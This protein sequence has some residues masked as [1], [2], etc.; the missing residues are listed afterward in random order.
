MVL[1][2]TLHPDQKDETITCP[3]PCGVKAA[4]D[5]VEKDEGFQLEDDEDID[6]VRV[7]RILLVFPATLHGDVLALPEGK[8]MS[9]KGVVGGFPEH[10]TSHIRI[11]A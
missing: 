9:V 1:L 4:V 2:Q 10:H 5:E 8:I 3:G 6:E 7:E 11:E